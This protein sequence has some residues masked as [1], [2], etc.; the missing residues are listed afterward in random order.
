MRITGMKPTECPICH[1]LGY[2][3]ASKAEMR[4]VWNAERTDYVEV[5]TL[6][7]GSGCLRCGGTGQLP[8]G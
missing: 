4:C 6:K 1:G 5:K 8:N 3:E 7:Q 2:T